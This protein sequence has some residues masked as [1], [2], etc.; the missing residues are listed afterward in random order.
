LQ[1]VNE[2]TARAFAVRTGCDIT[3]LRI[4]NVIS[5]EQY[6]EF[7]AWMKTPERRK[8]IMWSYVD[9]RD[10]GQIAKLAIETPGRGFEIINAAADDSSSD[11]PTAELMARFYPN[12]AVRGT[13]GTYQSL[14]SNRRAREVLGFRQQHYWRDEV[15]RLS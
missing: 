14:L 1:V 12:V 10:L 9:A 15:A 8:R 11:I 5:P 3:V 4:G 7:P 6:A 2:R 13:L